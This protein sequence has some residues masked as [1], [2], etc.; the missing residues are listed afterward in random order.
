MAANNLSTE[1]FNIILPINHPA[2]VFSA[3]LGDFGAFRWKNFIVDG[4]R[5][6]PNSNLLLRRSFDLQF[7]CKSG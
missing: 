4:Q 2:K 7:V 5:V 3:M 1:R 6:S